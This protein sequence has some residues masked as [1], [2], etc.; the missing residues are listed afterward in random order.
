MCIHCL[1]IWLV[2][3]NY[4]AYVL[5]RILYGYNVT[6]SSHA[7]S[8]KSKDW[9]DRNQNNVS[10]WRGMQKYWVRE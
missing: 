7:L 4:R 8:S 3:L 2:P 10:E 6:N 1:F 5:A 9:L